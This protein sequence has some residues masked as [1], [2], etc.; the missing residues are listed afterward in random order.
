MKLFRHSQGAFKIKSM[1][2]DAPAMEFI[3]LRDDEEMLYLSK[4]TYNHGDFNFR[5][6]IK[7]FDMAEY[8]GEKEVG[9]ES[10]LYIELYVISP[11]QVGEKETKMALASWGLDDDLPEDTE[12]REVMLCELLLGYGTAAG[13]YSL[14]G[15]HARIFNDGWW[16]EPE[17]V[18]L[19][20]ELYEGVKLMKQHA[21]F[22]DSM[23]GFFMDRPL[24]AIGATGWDWVK[25]DIARPIREMA[26][27]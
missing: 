20:E 2:K 9:T 25:G 22:V 15:G 19:G 18:D 10:P 3:T 17:G 27:G 14:V 13:I 6:A 7:A 12:E 1:P 16:E 4:E 24:N 5:Y 23:F 8:V 11:E 21:M 26:D